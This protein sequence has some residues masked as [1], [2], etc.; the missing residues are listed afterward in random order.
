MVDSCKYDYS[1][2]AVVQDMIGP[3]IFSVNS[4]LLHVIVYKAP[5][6]SPP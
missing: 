3:S 4:K 2:F 5:F 6:E 1:D